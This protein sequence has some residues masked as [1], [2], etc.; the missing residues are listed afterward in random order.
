MLLRSDCTVMVKLAINLVIF[1]F[2]KYVI[3]AIPL[4]FRDGCAGSATRDLVCQ[5]TKGQPTDRL[6]VL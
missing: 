3:L 1:G 5:K 2:P 4:F 6:T